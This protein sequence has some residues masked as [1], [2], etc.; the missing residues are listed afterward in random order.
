M[1]KYDAGKD[2]ILAAHPLGENDRGT[3]RVSAV[4]A[5]YDGGP[6]KLRLKLEYAKNGEWLPGRFRGNPSL[7]AAQAQALAGALPECLRALE[8]S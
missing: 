5:A 8:V 6:V 2:R 7:N 1:S 3:E 4:V